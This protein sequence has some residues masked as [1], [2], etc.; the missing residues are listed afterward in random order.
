ML[1]RHGSKVE[2][3]HPKPKV[4][5]SQLNPK[6]ESSRVGSNVELC[7]PKRRLSRVKSAWVGGEAESA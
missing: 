7:R 5:L 6:V 1:S 2:L 3:S 4:E